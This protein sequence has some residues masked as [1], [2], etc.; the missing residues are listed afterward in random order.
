[1]PEGTIIP[2][3]QEMTRTTFDIIVETMLSGP[4]S[5]DITRVAKAITDALSMT[6]WVMA[7]TLL[8]VPD[9]V[10]YPGKACAEKARQ[11]LRGEVRRLVED[12]IRSGVE[13]NDLIGL[14]LSTP[15]PETGEA[16]DR[17]DVA[18]NILTFI[19]AGHET[20]A[21]AL[22][23][24][25]YLLSQH[26]DVA[27]SVVSEAEAV[28]A[29]GSLR[30]EHVGSLVYTRQVLQEAMRLYPPVP[31]LARKATRDLKLAGKH[32]VA[33]A[34]T[35]FVPIFAIHRHHLLWPE[36]DRF[37]PARF[38][39]A[40]VK[41]RHRYAY[42]P[43]GAGPRICI[44]MGFALTEATMIL[45]TILREF[46]LTN[47]GEHPPGMKMMV[48]LRPASSMPMAISSRVPVGLAA[49]S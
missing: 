2:V 45:A 1:L 39:P 14:L 20:T 16:M 12:R 46:R 5:I 23:W 49:C 21:V 42:L 22:T 8:R 25:L 40:L 31:L 38:E 6:G 43:F 30:P 17:N 24:T 34:S 36:P 27:E 47:V 32:P 15:D 33:N 18:D 48:T 10:P 11:Y 28:T 13:R 44:G 19:T 35:V 37:D 3:L 7:T 26:P 9:W 4:Q 29:G 41:E